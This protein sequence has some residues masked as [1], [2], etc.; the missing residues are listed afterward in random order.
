VHISTAHTH[1]SLAL[2]LGL[3]SG[4]G[5][6]SWATPVAWC[7]RRTR[8]ELPAEM[9]VMALGRQPAWRRGVVACGTLAGPREVPEP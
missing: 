6:G 7:H 4:W 1:L 3:V 5:L 9:L 8:L 2:A